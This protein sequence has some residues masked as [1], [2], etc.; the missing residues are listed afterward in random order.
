MAH[1]DDK[2]RYYLERAV[3]QLREFE[4]K[5]IF[6]KDEIRTLVQKRTEYE[7]LI[8]SPGSSPADVLAYIAWDQSL[9]D[10]RA[11][12]CR[13][14]KIKQSTSFTSQGRIFQTFERGV[15][16]HPGSLL[17]WRKYLEY[18]AAAKATKRWRRIMTRALRMLPSEGGLWVVAGRKAW[19][20]GDM[21]GARGLFMRGCRFCTTE[22][23]VWLEYARLEMEWLAKLEKK[24]GTPLYNASVAAIAADAAAGSATSKPRN[25]YEEGEGMALHEGDTDDESDDDEGDFSNNAILPKSMIDDPLAKNK[26]AAVFSD[27]TAEKLQATPA[28]EGAIPRAIFD[29]AA[30]QAFFSADAAESFFDLFALFAASVPTAQPMLV[31]HVLSTLDAKYKQDAAT[32]NCR[33]KNCVLGL[34]PDAP[35]F[36]RALRTALTTLREG[37][38]KATNKA[39]FAAKSAAWIDVLLVRK[40]DELDPSLRAILEDTRRKVERAGEAA[41]EAKKLL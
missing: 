25:V 12:R 26:K 31:A 39:K 2:A 36:P 22:P 20:D 38:D 13:R 21:E 15:T 4:A 24:R 5:E 18:A 9:D 35:A 16:K 41:A 6:S 8:L 40:E 11:K 23:L 28:L 30:K 10:L 14:L 17:L 29:E 27:E 32:W 1:V 34:N 7:R 19:Q 37:L 33:V 3:P